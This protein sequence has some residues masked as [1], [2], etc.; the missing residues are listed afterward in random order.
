MYSINRAP[1]DCYPPCH[2][3]L[4]LFLI[5]THTHQ[6]RNPEYLAPTLLN[7]YTQPSCSGCLQ[8]NG[9]HP[10][11]RPLPWC[12]TVWIQC[13]L[14][15]R[16]RPAMPDSWQLEIKYLSWEAWTIMQQLLYEMKMFELYSETPLGTVKLWAQMSMPLI[17]SCFRLLIGPKFKFP[18][19][20][21]Q[22]FNFRIT[23][24]PWYLFV[25]DIVSC[26]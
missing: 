4:D 6:S 26:N 10:G 16:P 25:A 21:V 8:G 23:K 19:L 20:N 3:L 18:Y 14:T 1:L 24:S 9:S 22:S 5:F 17:R 12:C 2:S 7:C 11:R 13:W 15:S